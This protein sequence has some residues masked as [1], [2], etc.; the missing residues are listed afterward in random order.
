VSG[1]DQVP[2]TLRDIAGIVWRLLIIVA[3]L[4]LCGFIL[5]KIFPVVFA[6]FFAMLVTAW[7][8]PIMN[9]FNKVM[10]K[11]IAMLLALLVIATGIVAILTVVIRATISEG[12]KFF[13]AI[14]S[15]IHD[16]EEWLSTGP[17]Q[18]SDTNINNLL[19]QV[20]VIGKK[21]ATG[22]LGD[23]LGAVGSIG[24]LVI[25]GS[26]FIFGVIFFMLTPSKIWGWLISWMP[27]SL[28]PRIDTAGRIAWDSIAGYTRGIIIVALCDSL[29]VFVGLA[30]MRVPLAP[31]LA[32][33]VF[34]GAFIPVIGAP[35][36]TFFAAIVALAE[37]G[38][39]IALLV[40]LLTI[41]VGS[42]DG[43]VLQPLVMG[44]AVNLHPLAIVFAIA[45]GSIVLGIVGALVAVPIAGAIYGIAKFVTNRDP[46][47]PYPP[48]PLQP[49][50]P[51]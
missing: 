46:E 37:R 40:V 51:T 1:Q 21:V 4:V 25:A 9:F 43:D 17:L 27:S 7:A 34:I 19:D 36:A 10:P 31:A 33:V 18:M 44:K 5:D 30:V 47:H 38:P 45:A 24:T 6:L 39:L 16:I 15:G 3:G 41:V 49:A 42:F 23:A 32:A 20:N 8:G 50:P 14:T 2:G 35:V 13:E 12:P 48:P 28:A 22:A 26:V 29:L 11:V